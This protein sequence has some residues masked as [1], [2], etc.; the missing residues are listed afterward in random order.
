MDWQSIIGGSI[1][2]GVAKIISLFKVD[3]NLALQKSTELE[4]IRI[5]MQSDAAAAITA[6]LHD[7]ALVNQVEAASPQIFIAGWRP[8]IGWVCGS[9]LAAQFVIGPFVT[10]IAALAGHPVQF[11]TLDLSTLGTLLLGMLGLGT[12][13]SWEKVSGVTDP[14]IKD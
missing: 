10:W 11:P 3:P 8:F 7:Q 1:T 12:M 14:H 2:D 13:R 4:E 6:Q 9:G 5:K